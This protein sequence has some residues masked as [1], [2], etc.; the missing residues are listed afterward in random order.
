[1][2]NILSSVEDRVKHLTEKRKENKDSVEKLYNSIE[3]YF[4]WLED[5]SDDAEIIISVIK[6]LLNSPNNLISEKED[7]H[8]AEKLLSFFKELLNDCDMRIYE[9]KSRDA[10]VNL[11]KSL[12]PGL[13]QRLED[14]ADE[15]DNL[16]ENFELGLKYQ[17][18]FRELGPK[19]KEYGK[20]AKEVDLKKKLG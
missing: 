3:E 18:Q 14:I 15:L 5:Y 13:I 12:S 2:T 10:M 17:K 8:A 16:I 1:M 9:I 19:F 4:K 6:S 11:E 7:R 20:K